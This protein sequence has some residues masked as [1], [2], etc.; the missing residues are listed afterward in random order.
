MV[1]SLLRKTSMIWCMLVLSGMTISCS[2]PVREAKKVVAM[3]Q[4]ESVSANKQER[5]TL[6]A[7]M[8]EASMTERYAVHSYLG[9]IFQK[10]ESHKRYPS[11]AAQSE[12]SGRAVLRFT[13][14]WDGEVIDSQITEVT[15][16]KSFGDAALQALRQVGQLPPFPDEI[17]R[18]EL[19]VEVPITYQSAVG[20]SVPEDDATGT[21]RE[22]LSSLAQATD[23]AKAAM[24]QGSTLGYL[25]AWQSF[26]VKIRGL[27]AEGNAHAQNLLAALQRSYSEF[28]GVELGIDAD[29]LE[30]FRT[31]SGTE[32]W[33][34]FKLF[35]RDKATPLL[36]LIRM[37]IEGKDLIG[38]VSVAGTSHMAQFQVAGLNRRWDWG[39]DEKTG[40]RYAFSIRPDD[41]GTFYDFSVSDD[42]RAK[43]SQVFE[44]QLS[45]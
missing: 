9:H 11:I 40:C 43:P 15:G 20:L 41:T 21:T 8:T 34:C 37:R 23:E 14:R 35:D 36:T 39:C 17:R 1:A 22:L 12:L 24:E 16:H 4:D 5:V 18:H 19:L 3:S 26:G 33:Q 25:A 32:T 31:F 2:S 44:C 30:V 10:L 45:P 29:A 38:E 42:G 6:E 28:M 7:S 13:V 27:A